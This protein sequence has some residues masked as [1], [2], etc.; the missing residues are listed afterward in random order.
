MVLIYAQRSQESHMGIFVAQKNLGIEL[1]KKL[2]RAIKPWG[3]DWISARCDGDNSW[4]QKKNMFP[5][6]FT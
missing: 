1:V 4:Y 6:N 3:T 5:I 2:R